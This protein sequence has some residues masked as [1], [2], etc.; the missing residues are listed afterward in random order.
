MKNLFIIFFI[1]GFLVF[2]CENGNDLEVNKETTTFNLESIAKEH[3]INETGDRFSGFY[4]ANVEVEA[5]DNSLFILIGESGNYETSFRIDF[6]G[7]KNKNLHNLKNGDYQVAYFGGE[8]IV[9][10]KKETYYF[11][12]NDNPTYKKVAEKSITAKALGIAKWQNA[13]FSS[14]DKQNAI[15]L[16]RNANS[17]VCKSND[18]PPTFCQSGGQGAISCAQGDCEVTCGEGSYACC[19]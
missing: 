8:L 18:D 1:V 11:T 12:V 5:Q 16:A 13:D 7:N 3:Q 2:A 15:E 17:C 9:A 10:N 14:A 6:E 4:K 19:N